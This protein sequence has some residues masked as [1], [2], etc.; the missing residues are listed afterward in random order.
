MTTNPFRVLPRELI[1]IV[2]DYCLLDWYYYYTWVDQSDWYELYR[3]M[4]GS[5]CSTWHWDY[6]FS[7]ELVNCRLVSKFW[8]QYMDSMPNRHRVTNFSLSY[9]DEI[10]IVSLPPYIEV[11]LIRQDDE[12]TMSR[13]C[14]P[15]PMLQEVV[16]MDLPNAD[17]FC[18]SLLD[19]G[20]T[21]LHTVYVYDSLVSKE[22][23][24][25]ICKQNPML[26]N[27]SFDITEFHITD[28]HFT[29]TEFA[30][31]ASFCPDLEN[32]YFAPMLGDWAPLLNLRNL[33]NVVSQCGCYYCGPDA[34]NNYCGCGGQVEGFPTSFLFE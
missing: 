1:E 25:R 31:M 22:T 27:L 5:K 24:L 4:K 32:V 30:Q 6:R 16:I 9:D 3:D 2:I 18:C 10:Q 7:A 8:K 13:E 26:K 23:V 20:L 33:K 19:K 17:Q 29:R 15:F 21:S 34:T 28:G 11:L 14:G 12:V